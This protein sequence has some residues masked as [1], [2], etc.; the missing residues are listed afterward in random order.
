MALHK[1]RYVNLD[2]M[3][4]ALPT[5]RQGWDVRIAQFAGVTGFVQSD[6]HKLSFPERVLIPCHT[7]IE[8]LFL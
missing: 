3:R 4:N 2:G 6:G 7:L 8:M 5:F 1:G